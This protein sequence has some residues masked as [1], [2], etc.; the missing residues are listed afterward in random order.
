VFLIVKDIDN[1]DCRSHMISFFLN[2]G[3]LEAAA[4]VRVLFG[5]WTLPV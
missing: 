4:W 3:Q 1:S 5:C 2:G